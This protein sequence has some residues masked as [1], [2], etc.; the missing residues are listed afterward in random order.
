MRAVLADKVFSR[1]EKIKTH[2]QGSPAPSPNSQAGSPEKHFDSIKRKPKM[3]D[4]MLSTNASEEEENVSPSHINKTPSPIRNILVPVRGG[5]GA[6]STKES[7]DSTAISSFSEEECELCTENLTLADVTFPILCTS[8]QCNFNACLSCTHQM[9]SSAQ[10]DLQE[11]SDGNV[12]FLRLD[13]HCPD[14]RSDFM[15][16]LQD[17]VVLRE[18]YLAK[19]RRAALTAK[20]KEAA[21]AIEAE[22]EKGEG[23]EVE[24]RR[25]GCGILEAEEFEHRK[26]LELRAKYLAVD[27]RDE[28]DH[29]QNKEKTVTWDDPENIYQVSL[30][31][32]RY[33]ERIMDVH[34]SIC[35]PVGAAALASTHPPSAQ[36]RYSRSESKAIR[37]RVQYIDSK[38]YAGWKHAM[39][40]AEQDYVKELMTSGSEVS[41]AQAT[42]VLAS[43]SQMSK[44]ISSPPHNNS[45][46][47]LVGMNGG[48]SSS[49]TS[50]PKTNN[51]V[52]KL[53]TRHIT[54][55]NNAQKQSNSPRSNKKPPL[56]NTSR[57]TH[58]TRQGTNGTNRS[59]ASA[60][61]R[62]NS[63]TPSSL[64][65]EYA[66]R[67]AIE[68]M[69]PF[70]TR[71]PVS[72]QVPATFK[73]MDT[74]AFM[75]FADDE[76]LYTDWRKATARGSRRLSEEERRQRIR[77]T[78]VDDAYHRLSHNM[79]QVW[80]RKRIGNVKGIDH[81]KRGVRVMPPVQSDASNSDDV[82]PFAENAEP[83][84]R[85]VITSVK[86]PIGRFGVRVGDVVTHVDGERFLGNAEMLTSYLEQRR[87][88]MQRRRSI[89]GSHIVVNADK[90]TA[91]AL[92][93]LSYLA[94]TD[95]EKGGEETD[96]LML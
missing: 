84:K 74:H 64:Q 6:I 22:A 68:D 62:N 41:L 85:V 47:N 66:E 21:A 83:W 45:S 89:M 61:V 27:T 25:S 38:L 69:Y 15:V 71:M 17:V 29:E 32:H 40:E 8:K 14:C 4:S 67:R 19:E 52:P 72:F 28:P 39:S 35:T 44:T 10:N 79:W 42:E 82:D 26:N 70:P 24:L 43:I 93:I 34:A 51:Y 16:S 73:P 46:S 59:G 23:F 76:S 87:L 3:K 86:G 49:P 56:T 36:R 91:W 90:G 1:W 54:Y 65:R 77:V 81:V 63:R 53:S 20:E 11:A 88:D 18:D 95:F 48:Y 31:K 92:R 2:L 58:I 75:T 60:A 7:S 94:A 9:V 5:E 33:D 55:S 57:P 78:L 96:D 13:K 80:V 50:P 30:A 12:F 37:Q